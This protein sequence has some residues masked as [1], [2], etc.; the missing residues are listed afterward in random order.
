MKSVSTVLV[1]DDEPKA[2]ML[3]RNVIEPEGHRVLTASDGATALRLARD[4]RPDAIL[5]DVMMPETD[6]FEVCRQ[7]RATPAL[8]TVP[9][10]LLTALDD[11]ESRLHG[12]AAGADDFLTKPFDSVELRIRLRTI[13]RLN[14][15][16]RLYEES[17]RY[18][19]A[20]RHSE[21]GI[22][23]AELDG[24]ILLRNAAFTGL[25]EPA[26]RELP[27]FFDY[28]DDVDVARL[29]PEK[30]PNHILRAVE[31]PLRFGRVNP[32]TV[33]ISAGLVP[34]EG[35]T[36]AQF[37]VRDLTEK[38]SLE[39]Q[40]LRSQR[41]ELLGQLSGSVVHDMNNV[42]AAIGG[43][44][45]LIEFDPSGPHTPR[46]LT[47]IRTAVQRG[48]TMLRQLLLFARG[49]DGP[50]EQLHPGEVASEV[51]SLIR[52][53]FGGL[54]TVSFEADPELP[55]FAADS[56]QVHQVLM[57]LCV[58]ARDAMPQGGELTLR[59]SHRQLSPELAATLGPDARA[60][61]FVV[62]TVR[63]RGTGITPE[64]RARLFDPFF[65]TKPKGKGTGLATVL[66]LVRRHGG[67]VELETEVGS[68]TAFHCHFP[69]TAPAA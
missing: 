32:T 14:R 19:A 54:Y 24:A 22:V 47:N 39:A 52:G 57:N 16:Q 69:V 2:L 41:I 33:E 51:A 10:L 46:H 26:Q 36:L 45:G 50:L 6:G 42:L 61:D 34:W 29:H 23:L 67:F 1:V 60:G 8:A 13:F 48:A 11:R 44:A 53:S 59:A 66:R 27:N 15:Y 4:E 37:H 9:I 40:L 7:L 56:T 43:S 12:L 55:L 49:S 17:S 3:L 20:V 38:K 65:T 35:R 31:A 63:D 18:E 25:L 30:S 58:N 21:E 5:L 68:G 28:F 62:L 64:V